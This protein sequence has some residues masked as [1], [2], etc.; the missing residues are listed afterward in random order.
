MPFAL[1]ERRNVQM[2][3]AC[4]YCGRIHDSKMRCGSRPASKKKITDKD[5]IRSSYEWQKKRED[6]KQRDRYVCQLCIRGLY[7]TRKRYEHENLSVHHIIPL[8]EKMLLVFQLTAAEEEILFSHFFGE[9]A[10]NHLTRRA[11]LAFV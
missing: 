1:S 10:I 8:E 3:R 11:D 2:L 9:S 7:G 4:K 5:R 6:I